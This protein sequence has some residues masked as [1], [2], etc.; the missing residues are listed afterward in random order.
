MLHNLF[1]YDHSLQKWLAADKSD[2]SQGQVWFSSVCLK[3]SLGSPW[4]TSAS[5][6][7]KDQLGERGKES[8]T[9]AYRAVNVL[10]AWCLWDSC[11]FWRCLRDRKIW[12]FSMARGVP[13]QVDIT[14]STTLRL[15]QNAW[16]WIWFGHLGCLLLV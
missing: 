8:D 4:A 16:C 1:K 6:A 5:Q 9:A 10:W 3:G 13:W 14:C 7:E 2:F 11:T 15:Y 12:I